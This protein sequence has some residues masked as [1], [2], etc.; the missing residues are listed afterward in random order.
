MTLAADALIDTVRSRP[1]ARNR[2][3]TIPRGERDSAATA[4]SSEVVC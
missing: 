3:I 4:L 1:D 2:A